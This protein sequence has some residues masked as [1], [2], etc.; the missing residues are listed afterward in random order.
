MGLRVP[1]VS[2]VNIVVGDTITFTVE[3]DADSV[4]YFAPDTATILTPSPEA[5]VN[6]AAG[7]ELIYT[8]AVATPGSYG[9][10][11]EGPEDPPPS[12]YTFSSPSNPPVLVIQP[13]QAIGFS[14]PSNTTQT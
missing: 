13:G 8:F 2:P 3:Q 4:L 10:I 11:T 12:N 9:V 14:G 5:P 7:Q 6:L 1:S